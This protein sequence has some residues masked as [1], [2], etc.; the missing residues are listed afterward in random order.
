MRG[1]VVYESHYGNTKIVAEAIAQELKAE[2]HQAELRSVR[3]HYPEPPQGNIMFLG[4]PVR[5][6]SVSG[7]VKRYVKKLDE[8]VCEGQNSSRSGSC[9]EILDNWRGMC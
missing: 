9:G 8:D 5:M 4:S 2:G 3:Q 7:R 1:V 6:G